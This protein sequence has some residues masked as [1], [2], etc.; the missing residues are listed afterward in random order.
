VRLSAVS[1]GVEPATP[2][3]FRIERQGNPAPAL[4][5]TLEY[6][7]PTLNAAV[8][9]LDFTAPTSVVLSSG[10]VSTNISVPVVD[11]TFDEESEHTTVFLV[12]V[13]GARI[14]L[15]DNATIR[16]ED[17]D[18]LPRISFTAVPTAT[19]GSDGNETIIRF[20]FALSAA[21][22][23]TITV[24]FAASS[25]TASGCPNLACTGCDFADT[26]TLEFRFLPGQTTKQASLFICG[27]NIDEPNETF[28]A[29]LFEPVNAALGTSQVQGT[30]IDNDGPTGS[31]AVSP[32]EASVAV[33]EPVMLA[34]GW[35]VPG[36]ENWRSLRDL[37]LRIRDGDDIV[38]WLRFD[39]A[40]NSF[41]LHNKGKKGFGPSGIA[42]RAQRLQTPFAS[43]DLHDTT[44]VAGPT[45]P[46]VTLNLALNF[47]PPAAGQT[48]II[49]VSA[50]DDRGNRDD[51]SQAG[52]LTVRSR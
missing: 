14:G 11:D 18:P 45:S 5:I 42:G 32:Q 24:R 16:I 31:F 39:E 33:H 22:D 21:S 13:S 27:D 44:V 36:P 30:I 37:Q 29:R 17:N 38:F 23:K 46:T 40:S 20:P 15:P 12:G 52:V 47:K 48:Y 51:F 1:S 10:V 3:V 49:E 6:R 8:R 25:G 19:E 28:S 41:S 50:T 7:P 35:T 26:S 4:T 43:L 2:A 9:G 34:F